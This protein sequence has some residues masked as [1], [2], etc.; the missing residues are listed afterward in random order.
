MAFVC[1]EPF[2]ELLRRLHLTADLTQ[3]ELAERAGIITCA[4]SDLELR[5]HCETSLRRLLWS[6]SGPEM[7]GRTRTRPTRLPTPSWYRA[8]IRTGCRWPKMEFPRG[9]VR[10]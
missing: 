8:A 6:W 7:R 4:V 9:E 2:G 3:E 5:E 10:P 1:P